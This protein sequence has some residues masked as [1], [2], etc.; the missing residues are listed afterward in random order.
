[1]I[2]R[3]N[4]KL[5]RSCTSCPAWEHPAL[6]EEVLDSSIAIPQWGNVY[7]ARKKKDVHALHTKMFT[8][9]EALE[10]LSKQMEAMPTHL[11]KMFSAYEA[12]E[13]A[14][15]GL[16]PGQILTLEDFQV[17]SVVCIVCG[18]QFVV[19]TAWCAF[20]AFQVCCVMYSVQCV[21]VVFEVC[22]VVYSLYL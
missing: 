7:D 10:L 17:G 2:D 21:L 22:C 14:I 8:V 3:L 16:K 12:L 4:H 9:R 15:A 6:P 13:R 19:F 5:F 11:F 1:M 20:I 18:G